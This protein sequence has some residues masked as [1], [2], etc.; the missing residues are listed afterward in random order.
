MDLLASSGWVHSALL[1]TMIFLILTRRRNGA[2][3]S[4][5]RLAQERAGLRAA[6]IAEFQ[7]LRTVYRMNMDLIAT[8]AP[9]LVSGRPYFSIYR[10][11]M[12]RLLSLTPEEVAAVVTAHAASNTLEIAVSIG[13]RMR[14]R[15]ADAAL[16]EAQGMDLW[17]LQRAARNT[18]A[19]ALH[20]LEREAMAAEAMARRSVW[21]WLRGLAR[22]RA[23]FPVA[24]SSVVASSGVGGPVAG[25]GEPRLVVSAEH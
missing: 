13:M 15:K 9:Q 10:G 1:L 22:S 8:G 12:H 11:N 14:A 6:L 7:A 19:Q 3:E 18:A 21:G 24:A 16:W 5:R 4:R 20:L 17:R 25:A 2:F 23:M